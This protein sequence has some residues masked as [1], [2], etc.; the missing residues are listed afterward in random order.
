MVPSQQWSY[1]DNTL[2]IVNI[3]LGG[4]G[5]KDHNKHSAHAHQRSLCS[6]P[7]LQVLHGTMFKCKSDNT[8]YLG[9]KYDQ[10]DAVESN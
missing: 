8:R 2:R 9:Y 4:K 10:N 5:L 1:G 7:Q 6:E 3:A